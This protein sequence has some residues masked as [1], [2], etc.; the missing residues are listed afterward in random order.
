MQADGAWKKYYA[1]LCAACYASKVAP[2]EGLYQGD[3]PLTCPSCG[4]ATEDDYDAVYITAFAGGHD[5]IS[6]DAAFCAA[7]AVGYRRWIV[8]HARDIT[9]ALG[10]PVTQEQGRVPAVSA[11]EVEEGYGRPLR[12]R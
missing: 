6:A 9:P 3:A 4:K 8:E 7:D 11:R 12:V 2:L 10:S 1:K 5:S